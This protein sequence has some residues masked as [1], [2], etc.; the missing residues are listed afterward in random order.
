[1]LTAVL[2]PEAHARIKFVKPK[3]LRQVMDPAMLPAGTEVLLRNDG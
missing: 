3:D 1:M 2:P